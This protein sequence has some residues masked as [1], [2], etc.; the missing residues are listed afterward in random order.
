[1]AKYELTIGEGGFGKY[2]STV[3]DGERIFPRVKGADL[4]DY[5][6]LSILS[7]DGKLS[8]RKAKGSEEWQYFL[9]VSKILEV[10]EPEVEELD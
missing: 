2:A 10:N 7:V 8:R 5:E 4:E 6:I 1:M 3:R 9:E